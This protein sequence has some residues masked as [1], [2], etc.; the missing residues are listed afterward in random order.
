MVFWF[1]IVRWFVLL[2]NYVTFVIQE[3]V[4]LIESDIVHFFVR[5]NCIWKLVYNHIA[6]WF[7]NLC[8][9]FVPQ[10]Y[11]INAFLTMT[12]F[13]WLRFLWYICITFGNSITMPFVFRHCHIFFI[14]SQL[15]YLFVWCIYVLMMLKVRYILVR[16]NYV[17]KL[18]YKMV[19][20]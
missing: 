17:W 5:S 11:I 14:M 20:F 15:C 9:L 7:F 1:V 8:C 19:I 3:Q 12:Y 13:S 2:N 10:N 18:R 6:F 4:F 16:S